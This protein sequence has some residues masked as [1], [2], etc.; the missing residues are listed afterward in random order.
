MSTQILDPFDAATE[1]G[2]RQ[3]VYFGKLDVTASFVAL[4]KGQGKV[5]WHEGLGIEQRRTEIAIRLNPIDAMN[6]TRMVERSIIAESR[7]WARIV[8][9]S[10]RDLGVRNAREINGKWAKVELVE[11]GRS[12][13]N[14]EGQT[15]KD[16]T[17]KFLALYNTQAE[18]EAAWEAE[19]GGSVAH[20]PASNGAA[21]SNGN[22]SAE[23]VERDTALQFLPALVA[24]AGGD[25][26]KL[27]QLLAG[28]P[29]I[30][31]H[32][33]VDSPEVQQL[34]AA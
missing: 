23:N 4:I 25:R 32:F 14:R 18:C 2:E 9:A 10:L 29:L 26:A 31:K 21:A 1:A 5:V 13:V 24:Q 12:W 28:M 34:L 27:A 15:V 6:L 7:E 11:S 16:T 8:W 17:F 33:T 19:N 20:S 22:S 30:S 3:P